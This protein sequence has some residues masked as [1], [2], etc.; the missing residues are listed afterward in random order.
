[1]HRAHSACICGNWL[2]MKAVEA[3]KQLFLH[4]Y[5]NVKRVLLTN[6]SH[7]LL[8]LENIMQYIIFHYD[9]YLFLFIRLIHLQVCYMK[10]MSDIKLK[11]HQ[12]TLTGRKQ[13]LDNIKFTKK[14][15]GKDVW[16]RTIPDKRTSLMCL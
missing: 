3:S 8:N 5:C 16:K 10:I 2:F 15:K 1:M 13:Q 6:D 14:T 7:F 11:V 4:Y 12:T 9:M